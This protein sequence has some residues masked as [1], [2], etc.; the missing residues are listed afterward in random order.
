MI[1][2]YYSTPYGDGNILVACV[3][4]DGRRVAV[5]VVDDQQTANDW[6]RRANEYNEDG[7]PFPALQRR[8]AVVFEG[9]AA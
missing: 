8:L 7:T 3:T 5:Q 2:H 6:V 9:G 4:D 1:N